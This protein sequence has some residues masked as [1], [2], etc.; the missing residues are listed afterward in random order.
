MYEHIS[1][2][3]SLRA[4]HEY[5]S[6]HVICRLSSKTEK[7]RYTSHKAERMPFATH[8][9]NTA[10]S[11]SLYGNGTNMEEATLFVQTKRDFQVYVS[12]IIKF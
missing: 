1:V 3:S 4:L 7:R 10:T 12:S 2:I 5:T 11:H 6:M 8:T 9:R